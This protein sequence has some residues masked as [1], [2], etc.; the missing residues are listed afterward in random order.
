MKNI[1]LN[2]IFKKIVQL[3]LKKFIDSISK[4][5]LLG[6]Y[7]YNDTGFDKVKD[8]FLLNKIKRLMKFSDL[9]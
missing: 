1:F 8:Q 5:K 7:N 3:L 2:A 9:V 6:V 4:S